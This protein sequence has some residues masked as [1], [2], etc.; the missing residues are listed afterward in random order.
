MLAVPSTGIN[1]KDMVYESSSSMQVLHFLDEV[2]AICPRLETWGVRSQAVHLIGPPSCLF[3]FS[4][5]L[6]NSAC[7]G[8]LSHAE[9]MHDR[10]CELSERCLPQVGTNQEM[11]RAA[12]SDRR[13]AHTGIQPP[14]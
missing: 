1:A 11:T 12:H 9:I 10:R 2:F 7:H 5:I 6:V 4:V 8:S 13:S 14:L 3:I